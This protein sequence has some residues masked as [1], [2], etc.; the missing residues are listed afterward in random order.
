MCAFS[1]SNAQLDPVS[2]EFVIE[3]SEKGTTEIKCTATMDENWSVYS[4]FLDEGGPFPTTFSLNLDDGTSVI[5]ELEEPKVEPV[6]D[7]MFMMDIVKFK[8]KAVFH[9]EIPLDKF[10]GRVNGTVTYMTCDDSKCLPPKDINFSIP[11]M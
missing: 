5:L 3:Q 7:E 10:N 1:F 8:K 2:W 4:Q 11:L 6:Y 9:G